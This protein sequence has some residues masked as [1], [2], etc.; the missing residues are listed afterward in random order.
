MLQLAAQTVMPQIAAHFFMLRLAPHNAMPRSAQLHKSQLNAAY[1][2]R[3]AAAPSAN[4]RNR[5][6]ASAE[7]VRR[8][9]LFFVLAYKFFQM[10]P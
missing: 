7:M 1:I 4:W 2:S 6:A 9:R 5:V 3:F 8:E 10:R